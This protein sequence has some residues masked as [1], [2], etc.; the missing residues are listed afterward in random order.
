MKTFVLR[1]PEHAKA[2]IDFIRANAG[3][4]AK[5]GKP[6]V[7]SIDEFRAKRSSEQ[8]R[9]LHAILNDI[10]EQAVVNGRTYDAEVW[11]E[12]IRRRFIGTEELDMPDGSRIERG[13]STTTLGVGEFAN[14]IEIVQA[15]AQTELNVELA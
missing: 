1:A 4:Q 15:W 12:Q 14:L 7:V 6:L 11:K 2:M 9:K 8:N 10:A 5:A 13:I 3:D